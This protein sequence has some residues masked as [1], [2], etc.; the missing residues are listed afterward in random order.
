MSAQTR[1]QDEM[2]HLITRKDNTL[3]VK[4][5]GDFT[6]SNSFD[7]L[8]DARK[9]ETPDCNYII[10]LQDVKISKKPLYELVANKIREWNNL[11]N[12]GAVVGATYPTE[13][14]TIREI[15]GDE[16]PMLIPGI[17]A[18]GGDVE[19]T[20]KFGTNKNKENAIIN[21]SRGIIYADITMNFSKASRKEAIILKE[22]I[23][24]YR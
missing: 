3:L 16:I 21:S 7:V 13:L 6:Y 12:C 22:K 11:G 14:K 20:I 4:I 19:K 9:Q 5:I 2:S 24:I 1:E 17:G 23:N 18:Q 10:D 15:L 8:T